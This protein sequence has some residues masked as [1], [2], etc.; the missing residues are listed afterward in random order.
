MPVPFQQ[1]QGTRASPY[2][3]N[4]KLRRVAWNLAR[5]LLFHPS[6]K[7]LFRWRNRLL[8]W[9]GARIGPHTFIEPSVRIFHPWLLTIGDWTHVGGGAN[10]Y[11]LGPITIGDHSV[12]SQ[13]TVLCAGTHDYTQPHLPLLRPPITIGSGVW[14][15][16]EAFVGP[17]VTVGDNSVVGARAVVAKDVPPGVVVAGNPARVI[18]QRPMSPPV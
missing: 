18:K 7:P 6:P 13:D 11:N 1:L 12:V 3:R 10:L 5:A 14:I 2:S 17:N 4:E 15:A 16:A 8:R 9:F